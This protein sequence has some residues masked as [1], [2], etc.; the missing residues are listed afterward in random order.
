MTYPCTA[1]RHKRIV[2]LIF[3]NEEVIQTESDDFS[4]KILFVI[5]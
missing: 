5:H 3:L 2:T 1:Y 4:G